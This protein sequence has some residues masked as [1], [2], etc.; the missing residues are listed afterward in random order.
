MTPFR[1]QEIFVYRK[2]CERICWEIATDWKYLQ[3]CGRCLTG[4]ACRKLT[5]SYDFKI[6]G[7]PLSNPPRYPRFGLN[8]G[9]WRPY[10]DLSYRVVPSSLITPLIAYK[11]KTY[12]IYKLLT[13][14][15]TMAGL[16]QGPRK[17]LIP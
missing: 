12:Y 8:T 4:F 1:G 11:S 9:P 15:R 14:S 17:P 2:Y 16:G 3:S 6:S 10:L 7:I 13:V 5:K